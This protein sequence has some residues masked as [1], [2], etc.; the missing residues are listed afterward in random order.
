MKK[1]II[2][3]LTFF[4]IFNAFAEL[5]YIEIDSKQNLPMIR[6]KK[7]DDFEAIINA[8]DI[9]L[10]FLQTDLDSRYDWSS[11]KI[12]DAFVIGGNSY[13]VFNIEGYATLADYKA[14]KSAIYETAYDYSKA[15]SLGIDNSEF[16]YFYSRNSFQSIE[17][18][19]DAY[20]NGFVLYAA[21]REKNREE[22]MNR[23]YSYESD[24]IYNKNP[25]NKES[26]A[27]YDAKKLGYQNY[28]DYKEYLDYTA[29]GFKSKDEYLLAKSKGFSTAQDYTT[30]T[31]AGF[32]DNNEYQK[33]KKLGLNKKSDFVSYNEI[34]NTID[35]II[36][37]KKIDKKS[38]LTYYFIQ[39]LPKS[40]NA[41]SALSKIL[42]DS[43]N[44]NSAELKKALNFY[45]NDV[46]T[47]R[48]QNRQNRDQTNITSLFSESSL[49]YFFK[50]V[51]I[52]QIGYYNNKS[53]I[54]R[55]K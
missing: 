41:I 10:I 31:K 32:I 50:N 55:R 30:A 43:F 13:F 12:S 17:D 15:K 20:K 14:G 7:I 49:Q 46:Q 2:L 42:S 4:N 8:Y 45:A 29:K 21:F 28:T 34:T 6:I 36:T 26:E 37:D 19:K 5:R 3:I 27:Y 33:A 22:K 54:F 40:E 51:D 35:K 11:S 1:F 18:A 53:E 48:N 44:A 9:S 16:F 39:N 38:A 52:N 25:Q 24:F 23:N 47:A